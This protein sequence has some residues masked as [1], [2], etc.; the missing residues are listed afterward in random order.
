MLSLYRH[1]TAVQ[2][3]NCAPR[4]FRA[5]LCPRPRF[6]SLPAWGR[7]R[8]PYH[9]CSQ[10]VEVRTPI[11]L[12]LDGFQTI[13]LAFHLAVTPRVLQGRPHRLILLA[14]ANGKGA[15]LRDRTLLSCLHPGREGD[16]GALLHQLPKRERELADDPDVW[17]VFT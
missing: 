8:S 1:G 3:Q 10:E 12:P 15:H 4:P 11:H 14:N 16:T 17:G 7:L 9:A 6:R 2:K 5:L 13:D